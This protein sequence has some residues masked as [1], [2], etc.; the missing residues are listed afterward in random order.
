MHSAAMKPAGDDPAP[1]RADLEAMAGSVLAGH[2]AVV[3]EI[4]DALRFLPAASDPQVAA[5]LKEILVALF[6]SGIHLE[7]ARGALARYADVNADG[8]HFFAC[9]QA[10]ERKRQ[11]AAQAAVP[12]PRHRRASQR[13]PYPGQRALFSVKGIVLPAAIAAWAALKRGAKAAGHA[14]V[15][16]ASVKLTAL[17]GAAIATAGT[18]A[19]T[20]AIGGAVV[21]LSPPSGAH[22]QSSGP[23]ASVPGISA[24]ATPI[25]SSSL[26]ARNV[27]H[28]KAR[29]GSKEKAL[30]GSGLPVTCC[31]AVPQPSPSPSSSSPSVQ[32]SVQA[33]GTLDVFPQSVNLVT[34]VTGTATVRIRTWGGPASWTIPS[35]PADL[36]LAFPDGTPVVPG[37]SYDL[38]HA[39]DSVDLT[40]GLALN[41]DGSTLVSFTVGSATVSVTV[42]LPVPVPAVSVSPPPVPSPTDV[43]PSDVLPSGT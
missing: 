34:A 39:G 4:R 30:D 3:G 38:A 37:Q 33:A 36:T 26:I 25:P 40:V 13:Q 12:V 19:A 41:L 17:K 7:E 27:V 5:R 32:A 15:H 11:D 9:G 23:Q 20:L 6:D 1:G 35:I 2:L 16:G 18:A 14:P 8:A 21:V 22:G 28:P 24:S 43:L 29:R 31:W 10:F 42:P